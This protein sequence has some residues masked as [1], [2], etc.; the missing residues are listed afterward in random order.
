M[1][2]FAKREAKPTFRVPQTRHLCRSVSGHNH[3]YAR[4]QA[5]SVQFYNLDINF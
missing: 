3:P 1:H 2:V 4:I 5:N